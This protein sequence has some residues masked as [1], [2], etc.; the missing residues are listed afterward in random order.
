MLYLV[1]SPIGNLGDVSARAADVLGRVDI[2]AAEDTRRTDTLLRHLGIRPPR[3]IAFYDAV[4]DERLGGLVEALAEG[5]SVALV[6]DAG[7]PCVADPGYR[8][9]RA[10]IAADI[11]VVPIPGPSAILAGLVASGLPTDR[12]CF[13][14]YLP[15]GRSARAR[16]L[17]QLEHREVTTVVF[18]SPKRLA[19]S[20]AKLAE[21]MPERPVAVARELTKLHEEILRGSAREVAERLLSR[22]RIRGEITLVIAGATHR[23]TA[24]DAEIRR[25]VG[26]LQAEDL[27]PASVRRIASK[28]LGVPKKRVF[29]LMNRGE[30]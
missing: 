14:G 24:E 17:D 3:L 6:S 19:K 22:E 25:V 26:L 15:R 11:R 20:L 30:R 7:T 12:F 21:R 23:P 9:V 27:A 2:V 5:K 29:D 10:A 18:E 1:A 4:E 8:L 28:L 16:Y 13:D